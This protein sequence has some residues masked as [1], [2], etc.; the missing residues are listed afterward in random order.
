MVNAVAHADLQNKR[1]NMANR[2]DRLKQIPV[3]SAVCLLLTVL[4]P[5]LWSGFNFIRGVSLTHPTLASFLFGKFLLN[6]RCWLRFYLGSFSYKSH[7]DFVFMWEVSLTHPVLP[8]ILCGEF[9]LH[10][11]CWLYFYAVNFSYT[12][13]A[14]FI[15]AQG[16]S[17]T[18][19]VLTSFLCREFLLHIP[20]WLLFLCGEFHRNDM[21]R[22]E[23][24]LSSKED[25]AVKAKKWMDPSSAKYPKD[26]HAKNK[27]AG[28]KMA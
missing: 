3:S 23:M 24:D 12:S 28:W 6:M 25:L 21:G 14:A 20:S 22:N 11:P 16:V 4:C 18:H 17:M 7:A 15:F 19:S 5:E 27:R 13:H 1:G 2:H 10:I 9:L 8:S 26:N